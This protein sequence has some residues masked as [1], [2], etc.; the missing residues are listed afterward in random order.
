VSG[1]LA[2]KV[3]SLRLLP[4]IWVDQEGDINVGAQLL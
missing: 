4:H 3:W 2:A 1:M